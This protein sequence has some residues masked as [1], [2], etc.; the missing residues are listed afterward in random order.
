MNI[1]FSNILQE[2]LLEKQKNSYKK[3]EEAREI[4]QMR[5]N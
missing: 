5:Y 3:F 4:D 2:I 1:G